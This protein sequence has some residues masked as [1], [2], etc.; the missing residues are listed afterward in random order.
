MVKRFEFPVM[1]EAQRFQDLFDLI[2]QLPPRTHFLCCLECQ[3]SSLPETFYSR[4]G[5]LGVSLMVKCFDILVI[6][7]ARGFKDLLDLISQLPPRTHFV[8][9]G[10]P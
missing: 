3:G 5:S 9:S 7:E 4:A 10:L 1:Q 2:F 8:R 6:Q